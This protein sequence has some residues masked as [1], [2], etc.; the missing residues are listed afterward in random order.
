MGGISV[1]NIDFDLNLIKTFIYVYE[2]GSI[3]KA[4]EKFFV[5]QPAI[6]QSIKKIETIAKCQLFVRS[7]KGVNPT[8]NAKILYDNFKLALNNINNGMNLLY[9]E[10]NFAH[11]AISIG[12]SST[13]MRGLLLPFIYKFREKYQNIKISIVDGISTKLMENLKRGDV[14]IAIMSDPILIPANIEK[15]I[16]TQIEDCFI[17]NKNFQKEFISKHALQEYPII[18]Q[19][20][21]S[22]N[23]VFFDQLCKQ[24]DVKITPSLETESFGIITDLISNTNDMIGFSTKDFILHNLENNIRILKTDFIIEKRNICLFKIKGQ[25]LS[26]SLKLFLT[27]L[28]QYFCKK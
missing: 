21:P 5:S 15:T 9:E 1:T 26:N 8:A 10:N 7:P 27:E 17:V 4:S 25:M 13:L 22:N 11:G 28:E 16:I 23:R 14:D 24:N 20:S 18:L 12:S 2:L 6:T 3:S 19:K